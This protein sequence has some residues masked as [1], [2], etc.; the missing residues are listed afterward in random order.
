MNLYSSWRWSHAAD[1][2]LQIKLCFDFIYILFIRIVLQ[3]QIL[4]RV[5]LET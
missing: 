1:Y 2:P 4:I 5:T 3:L